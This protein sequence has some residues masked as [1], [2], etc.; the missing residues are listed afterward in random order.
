MGYVQPSSRPCKSHWYS[1]LF[2]LFLLFK[3]SKFLKFLPFLLGGHKY[4]DTKF[5]FQLPWN[6]IKNSRIKESI[7]FQFFCTK[8]R[9]NNRIIHCL[10]EGWPHLAIQW[11][12]SW[13][14]C[15]QSCQKYTAQSDSPWC[16][17]SCLFYFILFLIGA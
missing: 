6:F 4:V 12:I 1:A 13:N 16:F 11:R 14:Q 2:S 5:L 3:K 17:N 9:R 7:T 10:N 8:T 15:P